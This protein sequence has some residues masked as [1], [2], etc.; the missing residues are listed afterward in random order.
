MASRLHRSRLLAVTVGALL[1]GSAGSAAAAVQDPLPVGPDIAFAGQVNGVSTNAPIRTDCLGPVV[2]GETGHPVAGQYVEAVTAPVT[3]AVSGYTG[4]A[5]HQLEV[6]LTAPASSTVSSLIGA[7]NSFYVE[8]SIP[9]TL[10]VPCTG[11]GVV[12][13]TP[14]PTSPTARTAT[15]TVDF[16]SGP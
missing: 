3:S 12:A 5:A 10:T 16:L 9:V 4:S 13:F 6:S 15:V 14:D 7:L 1:I 11:T 8:L 2:V